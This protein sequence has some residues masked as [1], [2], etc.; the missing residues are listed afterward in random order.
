MTFVELLF[1]GS[2]ALRKLFR[3]L[4]STEKKLLNIKWSIVFNNICLNENIMPTFTN[5][6]HHDPAVV[7][8]RQTLEYRKHLILSEIR[9]KEK[10]RVD[11]GR[12]RDSILE[13]I[14]E[15]Q[16]DREL[17]VALHDALR[18][19][20]E[21]CEKVQKIRT[22]KKLNELYNG[23]VLLKEN[24]NSFVNLSNHELTPTEIEFLNLGLNYHIQPKYDKLHKATEMEMLYNQL[25]ELESKNTI[26]ID[27]RLVDQLA[28]E[29]GKHRNTKYK[30]SVTPS[31]REAAKALKS[32][33]QLI[34]RKADKSSI[35][36][37]MD[38]SEYLEKLDNIL[39]DT[40]KFQKISKDPTTHLKQEANKLISTLNAAQG[41]IHMPT[42]VGD[43]SPGYL[44]GNIKTHKPGN[45]LRPIISQVLT[46][47]Y[48]LA[49]TLNKIITP[50]IPAQYM[51]KSTNDFVDLLHS[52][53]SQ[54]IIA[55]LDVE[56]LFTNVPIDRTIDIILEHTYNND[57]LKAPKIPKDILKNLLE[58]C[59]KKAP[60]RSPGGSLY[61]QVEGVAMGSPLGPTFANFYMGHLEKLILSNDNS[62]PSIYTRYVDDIFLQVESVEQLIDLRERFQNNS[63]LKFTY[64]LSVQNKLPFLDVLVEPKNKRFHTT[65]YHKP[66]NHGVCLNAHSECVERYKKSVVINYLNRAYKITGNWHDFHNE[67]VHIKQMLINNNFS[68]STVDSLVNKFLQGKQN[69]SLNAEDHQ[70]NTPIFYQAQMHEHYRIDER[71]I[72]ELV[73]RNVKCNDPN[74]KLN[75]IIYYKNLRT[76]NLIMKNNLTSDP[77][78]LR[79][80]NVVYKFSCSFPH[81]QA[82]DYIGMTQTTLSRRLTMHSQTGSI[83]EHFINHHNEKPTRSQ[84]TENTIIM[85][86]ADNRFKLAVKEALLILN[87]APTIN[88]QH[89]NFTTILKVHAHR[90]INQT[91]TIK[92]KLILGTPENYEP[93]PP[94]PPCPIDKDLPTNTNDIHPIPSTTHNQETNSPTSDIS[95]P[96]SEPF[97]DNAHHSIADMHSILSKFRIEP[98]KLEMVPLHQ[99]KWNN[100]N[101]VPSSVPLNEIGDGLDTVESL[102]ISQRVKHLVRRARHK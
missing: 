5:I 56:S 23:Q 21:N 7:N 63:V 42:I 12:S 86:R 27:P 52:S 62:P 48:N 9:K 60:F 20:I 83:Y 87:H 4:E 17:V 92:P 84:L 66:T 43:F 64:E 78:P 82:E 44:Y 26:T 70:V 2:E 46:P 45:P 77:S 94:S 58:L 50:F 32:N 51:S 74:N 41:D 61:L 25:T 13:D 97:S 1:N 75:V 57:E 54:G 55:S 24:V 34:I 16:S 100:L 10:N 14:E 90:N 30:S 91:Q 38:K 6:K 65:V 11:V 59:T 72:R 96:S 102:T 88:R 93:S 29:S 18:L 35:Y 76:S 3:K 40:T 69:R 53:N 39:A 28:A 71:I 36:V 89:E 47:T 37:L 85:T 33:E 99:Y 73:T 31:L 80:T 8:T 67:V 101:F 19:V 81:S 68:N 22:M 98:D 49:K 95:F 15:F 79:Q